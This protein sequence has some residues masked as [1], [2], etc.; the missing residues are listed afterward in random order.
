VLS[1]PKVPYSFFQGRLELNWAELKEG[2]EKGVFNS[3]AAVDRAVDLLGGDPSNGFQSN[4]PDVESQL[5]DLAIADD[6]ADRSRILDIL[7]EGC[8]PRED[9]RVL[10]VLLAWLFENRSHYDDPLA[11]VEFVYAEFDYP[12]VMRHLIRWEPNYTSIRWGHL[13]DTEEQIRAGLL[14]RWRALLKD[15][16][17]DLA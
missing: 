11:E 9:D 6:D 16:G 17:F 2:M 8:S 15:W 5:V 10:I 1:I 13:G 7:A 12:L 14:K 4:L 3:Q